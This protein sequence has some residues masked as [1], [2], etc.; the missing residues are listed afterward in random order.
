MRQVSEDEAASFV[1]KIGENADLS[2]ALPLRC[3]LEAMIEN[4]MCGTTTSRGR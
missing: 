4:G 1:P 2:V 3:N